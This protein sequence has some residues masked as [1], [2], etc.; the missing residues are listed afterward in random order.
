MHFRRIKIESEIPDVPLGSGDV[1]QAHVM[2]NCSAAD[3]S[4]SKDL[5]R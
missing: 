3:Q 1:D 4:F 5:F 2:D